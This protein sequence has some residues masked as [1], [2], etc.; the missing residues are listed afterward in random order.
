MEATMIQP[1]KQETETQVHEHNVAVPVDV[2]IQLAKNRRF[3]AEARYELSV[4]RGRS[5][6]VPKKE[7]GKNCLTLK[8]SCGDILRTNKSSSVKRIQIL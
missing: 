3:L 8:L 4:R 2:Q 1:K 5:W 6:N 7:N